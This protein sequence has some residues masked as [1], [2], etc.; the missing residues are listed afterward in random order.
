MIKINEKAK[1]IIKNL[2]N[3]FYIISDFDRT[4]TA[5]NSLTS[6]SILSN[7]NLVSDEYINERNL[8]YNYYRPIEISND[9]LFEE[10]KKLMSEWFKKHLD[11]FIKY[12]LKENVFQKAIVDNK[13]M[14]FRKGAKEFLKSLYE[15]H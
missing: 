8:L 5:S 11:L 13:V 3:N 7:T 14:E 9:I 12:K 4:I 6:W 2:N 1:K 10:K 15:F